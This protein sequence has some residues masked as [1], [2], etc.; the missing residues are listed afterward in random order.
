MDNKIWNDQLEFNKKFFNDMSLDVSSLSVEDKIRWSK[1]F[2]LHVEQ[3]LHDLIDCLPHWKM[4]YKNNEHDKTLIKSNMKEEY[5]DALKYMM[6]LGHVLDISYE[7]VVNVY[8]AKTAVVKQKYEQNR[9]IE[10]LRNEEVVVFDIDG[11]INNYPDC[12]VDWVNINK[13]TSFKSLE[14]IKCEMNIE[15]YEKTKEEYR[16]SGDKRFQPINVDTVETITKLK[17]LGYKIV[18]YTVR[19]VNTYKRIYSDTL[20]WL[21]A[22]NIRFDSIYWSDYSK[23]DFYK[24]GLK[25]KFVVDDTLSNVV[26]FSKEG[27]KTY[28]LDKSYNKSDKDESYIRIQKVSDILKIEDVRRSVS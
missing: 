28:L 4:H 10:N 25:I 11:V 20:Q 12:F 18:L 16:L 15:E 19:P 9:Q 13:K 5:I 7:D 24:L 23:E 14:N 8:E 22:N 21:N 3:E 1:E 27:I 26:L 6:G 17:S 2:V